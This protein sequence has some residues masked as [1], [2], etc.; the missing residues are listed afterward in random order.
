MEDNDFVVGVVLVED[1]VEGELEGKTVVP[2][3]FLHDDA[4]GQL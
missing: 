3:Q 2:G 1:G 4:E